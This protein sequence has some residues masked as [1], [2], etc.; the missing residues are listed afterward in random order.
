MKTIEEHEKKFWSTHIEPEQWQK[1][2][3]KCKCGEE[4]EMNMF[5][6]LL[7][8]P[9]QRQVRCLKCGFIGSVH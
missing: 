8:N 1:C 6:V 3:I 2:G 5:M 7:S 4:L 9:P